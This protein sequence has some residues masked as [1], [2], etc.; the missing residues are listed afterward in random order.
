MS[1]SSYCEKTTWEEFIL[2]PAVSGA[3]RH[4]YRFKRGEQ[5]KY[6]EVFNGLILEEDMILQEFQKKIISI[7]NSNLISII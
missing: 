7:L 6:Q 1:L 4:T 2:K 5:E 3:A